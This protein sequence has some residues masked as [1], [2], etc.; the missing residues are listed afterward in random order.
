M[1]RIPQQTALPF[2]VPEGLAGETWDRARAAGQLAQRFD[3]SPAAAERLAKRVEMRLAEH[4]VLRVAPDAVMELAR[5]ELDSVANPTAPGGGSEPLSPKTIEAAWNAGPRRDPDAILVAAASDAASTWALQQAVAREIREAHEH[6]RILIAG[7]DDPFRAA[8]VAGPIAPWLR[9]A[10][11]RTLLGARPAAPASAADLGAQISDGVAALGRI[12]RSVTLT[13]YL[14]AWLPFHEEGISSDAAT[15]IL[16]AALP[17]LGDGTR[18]TVR[19]PLTASVAG[20]PEP[21]PG[22]GGRLGA[23]AA[24]YARSIADM[25]EHTLALLAAPPPEWLARAGRF[26]IAFVVPAVLASDE[27]DLA[28]ERIGAILDA[29]SAWPWITFVRETRSAVTSLF[30]SAPTADT[31][32]IVRPGSVAVNLRRALVRSADGGA[33]DVSRLV[34]ESIGDAVAAHV[35]A[36]GLWMRGRGAA[37]SRALALPGAAVR[38]EGAIELAGGAALARAWSDKKTGLPEPRFREALAFMAYR[39]RDAA[40]KAGIVAEASLRESPAV[41]A[42]LAVLDRVHDEAALSRSPWMAQPEPVPLLA[43]TSARRLDDILALAVA[44]EPAGDSRV[45]FDLSLPC[46]GRRDTPA[47]HRHEDRDPIL[48][49]HLSHRFLLV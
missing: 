22:P 18:V 43:L 1:A 19:L 45:A 36:I 25:L 26:E 9:T 5:I 44:V 8:S 15:A 23:P 20:G 16:R 4:G 3:L 14:A 6:G 32:W 40:A 12:A 31:G 7:F 37:V 47:E 35:G 46:S 27:R 41:A 28:V 24:S 38:H 21:I 34:A 13:R 10:G 39:V 11:A 48:L 2:A 33:A 49:E 30:G 42:R 29:A 17:P